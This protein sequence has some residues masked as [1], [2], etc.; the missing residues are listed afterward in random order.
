MK[1]NQASERHKPLAI[2]KELSTNDDVASFDYSSYFI[3]SF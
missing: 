3:A 1:A 2:Y